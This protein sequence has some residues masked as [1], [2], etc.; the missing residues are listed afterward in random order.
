MTDLPAKDREQMVAQA[1][2]QL[3]TPVRT[4]ADG[5]DTLKVVHRLFDGAL[6]ESVIMRYD[7]R[8]TMCISS[9]AGC[10]MNSPLLLRPVSRFDF[11]TRPPA[12]IVEQVVAGARYLKQMKGLEEAEGGSWR[13]LVRC[14]FQY[15]LHGYGRGA[16]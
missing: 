13:I 9:Q 11:A 12:E 4:E 15:C 16:C 3:L 1:M 6:I 5:G 2:P 7:N 10:G 14:V 8:V